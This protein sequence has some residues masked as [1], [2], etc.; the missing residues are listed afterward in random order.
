[1][2]CSN[3]FLLL[4]FALF[5]SILAI[6]QNSPPISSDNNNNDD[7]D[8]QIIND[9]HF[10]ISYN[11]FLA[12]VKLPTNDPY[13]P[14]HLFNTDQILVD[15]SFQ[16]DG[17]ENEVKVVGLGGNFKNP[18][19]NKI[20][21]NLSDSNIGPISITPHQSKSFQQKISINLNSDEN[22]IYLLSP[23]IYIVYLNRLM[24]ITT[25]PQLLT[26][27]DKPVSLFD[28]QLLSIIL[29]LST[30]FSALFYFLLTK[31]ALPYFGINN[32]N[33]LDKL[34]FLS[35]K[36]PSS[37]KQ[38]SLD[39]SSAKTTGATINEKGFDESWLPSNHLQKTSSK[40][41]AKSKK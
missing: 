36:S 10:N 1:M 30:S 14:I 23:N 27:A 26:V 33:L 5:S 4:F 34:P 15:Y 7:D 9:L 29:T 35:K 11:L 32:F 24:V 6:E 3:F 41:S 39:S 38:S 20:I 19:N 17:L 28:L 21:A 31:F 40:K 18:L 22:Q 2:I 37:I 13:K 8:N 12:G 16:N 25:K